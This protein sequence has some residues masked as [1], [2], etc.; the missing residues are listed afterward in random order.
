MLDLSTT[1]MGIRLK[2]PMIVGAS[3]LTANM[4]SI[5]RLEGAGAAA[6]V[7]KSLFEEQIQLERFMFDE[8][9][10]KDN[11]RYAEM[12]T[13]RP[14]MP[15]QGVEEHV[16]WVRKAKEAVR[17]PVFASLNAVTHDAW[18]CYARRLEQTGVDGLEVNLFTP[19]HDFNQPG[20]VLEDEQVALVSELKRSVSIPVSVKLSFFYTNPL[21]VIR[22]MD[23]AGADAF[24]VFNRLFDPDIDV[25]SRRHTQPFNFSTENDYRLPLRYAGLLEGAIRASICCA[26]GI[27]TGEHVIKMLLAG[28]HAVQTVSALFA[29]GHAQIGRMLKDLSDWME[30]NRFETLAD[31]TGSLS[32]RNVPDPWAYTRSQYAKLLMSPETLIRNFPSRPVFQGEEDAES[33]GAT[34]MESSRHEQRKAG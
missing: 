11:Y 34:D 22:R 32:R 4:A 15:F 6:I 12:I 10:D 27:H 2:N 14:H 23:E 25:G 26:T 33:D 21:N 30:S 7:T 5:Q 13:V 20:S 18:L 19:P 24:V 8:S 28:A 3:A 16:M 17:I 29:H 1:Y 9:L 31:F